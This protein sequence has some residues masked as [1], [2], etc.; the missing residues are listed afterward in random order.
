MIKLELGGGTKQRG[1]DWVNMDLVDGA[2]I[3]HNLDVL[4]W[5]LESGSVAEVYSSHCLEHLEGP[6]GALNE[7]CRVCV[8]GAP[9][10][11]RVPHPNSHLAMI[12][13]HKHVFSPL[14]AI[15]MEKHFP[16][17]HWTLPQ[18]LRLDAI[19]YQPSFLLEEAR[20][21]LPFL[22][23]LPDETVMK[24]IQ[25]TCHECCFQYTVVPNEYYQ[26]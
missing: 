13:G 25:G 12:H 15:N 19:R 9:V 10:E 16:R 8:A 26:A 3:R 22:Y 18:R 14:A 23:G 4:P 7:L 20:R 1:G 2:D 5:P 11:I 21:E 24:W 17:E 6:H